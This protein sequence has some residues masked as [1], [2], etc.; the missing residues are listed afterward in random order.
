MNRFFYLCLLLLAMMGGCK[1]KP[2]VPDGEAAAIR[3]VR[4]MNNQAIANHDVNGMATAWMDNFLLI[5][6]RDNQVIGRDQVS[7]IFVDEFKTKDAVVYI[8]SPAEIKVMDAW[9]MAS[10]YGNWTGH[11]KA[12][13]DQIEIG[14]SYFAKWH[15]VNGSW[16]LRAEVFTPLH[17]QGGSYCDQ[18]P[19]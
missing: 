3:A 11:W 19:K 1:E 17:C 2:L 7:Q 18:I 13:D 9:N 5:S 6:S 8:R 12:G 10:E 4:E 14:G 15:K 16:L